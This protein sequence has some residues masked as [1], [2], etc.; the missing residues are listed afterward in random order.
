MFIYILN[1]L[2][3]GLKKNTNT[4]KHSDFQIIKDTWYISQMAG[5]K[6]SIDFKNITDKIM[7]V[8]E[9][10]SKYNITNQE[11]MGILNKLIINNNNSW[12]L[13]YFYNDAEEP[14]LAFSSIINNIFEK[15]QRDMYIYE[16]NLLEGMIKTG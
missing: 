13:E 12:I 14:E 3:D 10:L 16:N 6:R 2:N 8:F 4:C 15:K 11:S 1:F 5:I 9:I 7:D